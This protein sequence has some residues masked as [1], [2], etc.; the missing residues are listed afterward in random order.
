MAFNKSKYRVVYKHL[1]RLTVFVY[2]SFN[3]LYITKNPY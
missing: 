1:K 2:Y 3:V